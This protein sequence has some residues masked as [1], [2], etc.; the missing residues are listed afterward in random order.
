MGILRY[1]L[2]ITLLLACSSKPEQSTVQQPTTSAAAQCE[3]LINVWCGTLADCEVNGNLV[4]AGQRQQF[5]HDCQTTVKQTL[6]CAKAVSVESSYSACLGDITSMSCLVAPGEIDAGTVPVLPANC[7]AVILFPP[8][9]MPAVQDAGKLPT[10][11]AGSEQ[12][13]APDAA[14]RDAGQ[15]AEAPQDASTP[16]ASDAAPPFHGLGS[17]CSSGGNLPESGDCVG[18]AVPVDGKGIHYGPTCAGSEGTQVCTFL[19]D[20]QDGFSIASYGAMTCEAMGGTCVAAANTGV[21]RVCA[22]P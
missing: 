19:C 15:D 16:D 11:D 13:A 1:A 21:L 8:G 12:D 7:D 20:A 5:L 18:Y 9:S 14:A 3:T 2:P 17:S 4:T 6:P 10:P 22:L